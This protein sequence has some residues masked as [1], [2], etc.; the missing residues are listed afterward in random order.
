MSQA[1]PV[2]LEAARLD[3]LRKLD[4]LDTPPNEA[5]DRITRMAAQLFGLPIAAVSLTDVDRQWFK[6]RVGIEH[7]S[8]P[9]AN[10]PC[11]EVTD[12]RSMLVI[13]DLEAHPGYR[14]SGLV[15]DGVR[16]YAGAPLLTRDGYCLG[17]LYVVGSA[18]R[19]I[20]AAERTGLADLAAMVMAQIELQHAIGR[21]D[22]VSGIPNRNQFVDDLRDLALERPAGEARLAALV[23]LAT[24]EQVSSAVRAMGAGFVDDIVCEAARMLRSALGPARKLYH[25]APAQFAFLAEPG[26]DLARFCDWL[27]AWIALRADSTTARFVTTATVGVCPF[28]TGQADP[29]DLL[30]AMYSAAHDAIEGSHRVRVFSAEQNAVFMRRFRIANEFG[31][32]LGDDSQLRLVFQPKIELAT[33]R[34]IGAEALLRWRH[35]TLG[36]VSPGEFIPVIEQTSLARA[37]TRWVL[38][39][40]LRQLA[41]WHRAGLALQL[42]VNVSAVNL[43]EP[44]FCEHV[45]SRLRAHDLAPGA[46]AIEITE[47]ALMSKRALAATTLEGLAAGGVQLA[48]DDF[49]TGYSSLA[50][51]QSVPAK[52]VKIDQSFIRDLD[53]DE[54]KRALVATMIKLSHDLGQLVVAEGVETAPVAQFLASAGCDQVQGYL[55]ARPQAPEQFEA[56]ICAEWTLARP[57]GTRRG[58]ALACA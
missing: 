28:A 39:R 48:I 22:P 14:G 23:N 51:L 55:Y 11:A 8:I 47:S 52:V 25:V 33:G 6:S 49:G 50:Y 18:P 31:A 7:C 12:T 34:C 1:P 29:F 38:E 57:R 36:E 13:P 9:R 30:R 37:A 10:A 24:P 5:F 2:P 45:L 19:T 43:L 54:R 58:Q 21:I 42:A 41:S 3:A 35:P 40:A 53:Q 32:A 16:F 20:S 56:W 44:D 27:A 4:L 15:A 46:L 17:A 26:A